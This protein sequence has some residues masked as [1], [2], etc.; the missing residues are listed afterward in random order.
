[1]TIKAF[2]QTEILLPRLHHSGVLVV[3]DPEQ[4]YRELCLELATDT[5]QVVDASDSSV[6]SRAAALAGL[7]L[8]GEKQPTLK[9]LLIYVPQRTPLDDDQRQ[10]DPF[11][12]YAACG[13]IFPEGDGDEYVSLCLKAKP[14]HATEIR[15]IFQ[16]NASPSFA[17]ID[18]I[19][20]GAGWPNLQA[21]LGV[22]SAREIMF[23]LLAPEERQKKALQG[24]ETW[25]TEAKALLH[26]AL[27]L[28]LL[29]RAK[30]YGPIADELW[31]FLLF[32]EFVFDLPEALPTA[33]AGVPRALPE[34]QP[35]VE[36]LCDML[37]DNRHTQ[38]PYITRAEE[39]EASLGLP[40]ACRQ[41]IDLGK[42]DTF[43]FEERSFFAQAVD[44]LKRD[45]VDK[46][47][48]LLDRHTQ[49]IWVGSGVNQAQWQIL[50]TAAALIEGCGDADRH[51]PDAIRSQDALID[52]YLAELRDVD[53][54]Q[55]EFEQS[56]GTYVDPSGLLADVISLARVTY[57]RLANRVQG[58]FVRHLE[59]VGWPP[60]GR[61]ANADVFDRIVEPRIQESGRR[62]AL[63][64]IDALRYELGVELQKQLAEGGQ[65]EL[66]AAFAQLPSVTPVGMASL[67]PGAGQHLRLTRKDDGLA[68]M[69]GGQMLTT[70]AQRMDILQRRYGQRF[71][72]MPLATFVQPKIDL[73]STVDLLVIRSNDMDND[74]ENNPEAAPSRI[75]HTFRQIVGAVQKLRELGFQDAVIVADHGFYLN[76]AATAGDVCSKPAGRWANAHDR[77][78]LG[79]GTA[80]G[81]SVVVSA[82]SLGI[83]GEFSQVA[84]PK[85]MVAYRAGLAYFHGGASLQEAVVPVIAVKLAEAEHSAGRQPTVTLSY[86]R[87]S[88][89][90]TTRLPVIVIDIG[91]GDLFWGAKSF[92]ILVEAHDKAG[93]VVGEA[94]PGAPV[95]AATRTVTLNPDTSVQVTLKMDDVFE[96]KFSI[97]ALDPTTLKTYASIDL[98]TDYTV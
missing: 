6:T 72:E 26:G 15:R 69:L 79:D 62:V 63:L 81:G 7:Q 64:L 75:N 93:N 19:G 1:M 21:A 56:V 9:E 58:A 16:E 5:R 68:P 48:Q 40:D 18:A 77:M 84:L 50:Q 17:V 11:A 97:K 92:E 80:D 82:E 39:I 70:V 66:Q 25:V 65:V 49:S 60:S 83:S 54:R 27:G 43:P 85:A 35:L 76:T 86:K 44:A 52:F 88:K 23:A 10:R 55:R 59:K 31:R 96:G 12:L 37:R 29:T 91:Q 36:D 8:L 73:A 98:E 41:I 3:Y 42:R 47:R 46:L 28:T 95:N 30:S 38:R 32:S 74:F 22:Q 24:Q 2:I 33:L 20:G 51:L 53:R 94:R 4:R 90:I 78:L 61:L 89:R 14:D 57:Q 71:A 34:A 13:A 67:L 87:A 45:N